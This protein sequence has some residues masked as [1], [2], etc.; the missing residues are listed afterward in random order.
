M[1]LPTPFMHLDS[2]P[3][4]HLPEDWDFYMCFVD[5]HIAS[6]YLN[7]ALA[8]CLPL[9]HQ[10]YV[11]YVQFHMLHPRD[12]GLSSDEDFD[13]LIALE[14]RLVEGLA[15]HNVVYVGSVTSNGT[16]D[17]FFYLSDIELIENVVQDLMHDFRPDQYHFGIRAD[18][19]GTLYLNYLFP[20]EQALK[21]IMERRENETAGDPL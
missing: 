5:D 20:S 19:C 12:D 10:K 2:K 16:R 14:E 9:L 8:E 15:Q 18:E 3:L 6:I 13:Q 11:M 7:L 1:T 17:F 4:M 21:Q